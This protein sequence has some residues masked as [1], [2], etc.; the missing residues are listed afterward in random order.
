MDQMIEYLPNEMAEMKAAISA[1]LDEMKV[2]TS[3][4]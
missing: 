2:N 4:N 3:A 1:G